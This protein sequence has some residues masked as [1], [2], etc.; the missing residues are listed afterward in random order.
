MIAGAEEAVRIKGHAS[1]D[2]QCRLLRI[3]SVNNFVWRDWAVV[4]VKGNAHGV[5]ADSVL[6]TNQRY[7]VYCFDDASGWGKRRNP[8]AGREGK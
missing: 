1:G 4:T 3:A 8:R 6:P 5:R 2:A 7:A